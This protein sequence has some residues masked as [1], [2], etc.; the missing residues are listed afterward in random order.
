MVSVSTRMRP[1][2]SKRRRGGSLPERVDYSGPTYGYGCEINPVRLGCLT[3]PLAVCKYDIP[4]EQRSR[5]IRLGQ[6]HRKRV[7]DLASRGFSAQAIANVLQL[8][9]RTVYRYIQE[10][11]AA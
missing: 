11:K 10:A 7:F 1:I 2:V 3:C 4:L 6:E 9:T 5:R 8:S